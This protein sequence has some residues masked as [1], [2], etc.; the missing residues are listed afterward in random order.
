MN[1]ALKYYLND[2]CSIIICKAQFVFSVHNIYLIK[3]KRYA[4]I[5]LS[6][7]FEKSK[8]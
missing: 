6:G 1:V 3:G 2:D 4:R 5:Y 8:A 7:I